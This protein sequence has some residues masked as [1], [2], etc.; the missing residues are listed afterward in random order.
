MQLILN[1]GKLMCKIK[2]V[3][4]LNIF[5]PK[6]KTTKIDF[7]NVDLV[8]FL[9]EKSHRGL[10]YSSGDDALYVLYSYSCKQAKRKKATK[11]YNLCFPKRWYIP[12]VRL[13]QRPHLTNETTG[14]AGIF[15][16][17]FFGGRRTP[18]NI[19][20]DILLI[21]VS[22]LGVFLHFLILTVG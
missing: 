2:F 21:G 15:T 7:L 22:S 9:E 8:L 20:C 6:L 17:Q 4:A 3:I 16:G 5:F 12:N 19:C 11:S 10:R 13:S 14:Q 18:G 1:Q